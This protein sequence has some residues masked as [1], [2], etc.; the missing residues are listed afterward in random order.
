MIFSL[1]LEALRFRVLAAAFL[2]VAALVAAAVAVSVVAASPFPPLV[3]SLSAHDLRRSLLLKYFVLA[4]G[5][6]ARE[7][8]RKA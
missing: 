6:A 1:F 8:K 5:A 2:E 3:L 7:K 4:A